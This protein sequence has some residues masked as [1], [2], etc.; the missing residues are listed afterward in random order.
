M[1]FSS[2]SEY[3]PLCNFHR[4]YS[5]NTFI[6]KTKCI[7]I[8]LKLKNQSCVCALK[9]QWIE[10]HIQTCFWH[11]YMSCCSINIMGTNFV[12]LDLRKFFNCAHLKCSCN[13]LAHEGAVYV[14]QEGQGICTVQTRIWTRSFSY[15]QNCV[16]W[17]VSKYWLNKKSW[18]I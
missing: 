11:K 15:H 2:K 4:L 8:T 1:L 16:Y 5:L 6:L 9:A 12:N 18:P 14:S 10:Y 7:I 3:Q 17:L 13:L